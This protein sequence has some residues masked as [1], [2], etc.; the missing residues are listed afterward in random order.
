VHPDDTVPA[1]TVDVRHN[2][3]ASR[4]EAEADGGLARAD[5]RLHDGVMR[6]VHTEVPRASEGRGIAGQVVRAALDYARANGLRVMPACSYV[7]A[8]MRRHPDTQDLLADT[9][10]A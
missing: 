5:Y 2:T 3:A 6:L 10:A 1:A 4:F 7:R 8:Y 9:A